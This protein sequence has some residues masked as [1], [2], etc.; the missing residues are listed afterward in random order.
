MTTSILFLPPLKH[1][2]PEIPQNQKLNHITYYADF[3]KHEKIKS[4]IRNCKGHTAIAGRGKIYQK[5][6]FLK[7]T[8]KQVKGTFRQ[9]NQ[10]AQV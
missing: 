9:K 2:N 8:Q 1:P 10:N 3:S 4:K 7:F 6:F 5:Y